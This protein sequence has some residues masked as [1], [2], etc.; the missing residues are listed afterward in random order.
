MDAKKKNMISRN[1]DDIRNTIFPY[2]END[3]ASKKAT[4]K[5]GWVMFLLLMSCGI[6]A[7]LVAVSFAH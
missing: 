5:L 1:L 4:K 6:L 3:S 2:N 7:M